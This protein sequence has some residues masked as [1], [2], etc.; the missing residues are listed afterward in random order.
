MKNTLATVFCF[1]LFGCQNTS[2]FLQPKNN[3][4]KGEYIY[5]LA[6]EKQFDV[7]P[8]VFLAKPQYPWEKQSFTRLPLI[9]KEYFRCKGSSIN[10]IQ[11]VQKKD[12]TFRYL[13]C[14]GER[15]SLPLRESQEFIYPVLINLLNFIQKKTGQKVVI[16]S[17]HRCPEHNIYVDPINVNHASKHM[18]GAEV[19]F[20]VQG[21]EN[22]PL[23]IIEIIQQY[24]LEN[25]IYKG[26]KSFEEFAR[27][28]KDDLAISTQPWLNK[29]IFIKLFNKNEGRNFDNRHPYPYF[30]IQVRYDWDKKERVIYNHEDAGR[31]LRN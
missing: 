30:S 5:R 31:Y 7:E 9:T 23:S 8:Q 14:S 20:Y 21:Y 26:L 13:D 22:T 25:R 15:H 18:I 27:Y 11:V 17:G 28:E 3:H 4:V 10:P 12:Q 24:Y 1:L 2:S 6:N 29:E 19:S 16:T